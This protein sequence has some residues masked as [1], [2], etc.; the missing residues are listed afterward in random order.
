MY[1]QLENVEK[2]YGEN[3]NRVQVLKGVNG[4]IERGE[5]CVML[6]PSGSGKSTLLNLIGGI[7]QDYEG[8]ILFDHQDIRKIKKYCRR[9]IGFIFQDFNLIN[10]LNVKEN[11]L[12][13]K[14]F[15]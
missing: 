2:Y 3:E 13:A 15:Y 7:D 4:S 9:H 12:L 10:W 11:Y 5:I 8:E 6:G 14:I 1:L